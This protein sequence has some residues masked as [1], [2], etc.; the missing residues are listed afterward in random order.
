LKPRDLLR[1]IRSAALALLI[2][3]LTQTVG[4]LPYG[5]L[6]VLAR[7]L[8]WLLQRTNR[9][10]RERCRE[11]LALAF[12]E[13]GAEELERLVEGCFV[14]ASLNVMETLQLLARG[15][16]PLDRRLDIE[17]WE[18]VESEKGR[19]V[20][21]LSCHSGF[22]EL[23][24]IAGRRHGVQF[25][26]IGRQLDNPTFAALVRRI[27]DTAG[28]QNIERGSPEGRRFLRRALKG[29]APLVMLIDQDTK[30]DGT[31]VPF[32]GR[33]AFTP[34]GAAQMALGHDMRVVPAFFERRAGG[35]H[36]AR[37]LP[38]LDLPADP[39]GATAVM[40]GAI[41][42]HIRRHPEQW[43]WWHRRWRRQP[44]DDAG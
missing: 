40:T 11:H 33:P 44:A 37:F 35:R 38:A 15:P 21:L 27:R 10:H 28:G 20:L 39:T 41:E 34:L 32:F 12:P 36:V 7:G 4:R 43:V 6:A 3:V 17:G 42:A 30:V 13:L 8:A 31:W 18:N 25:F 2:P 5:A 9:R 14:N 24:G 23:L 1:A 22:W 29:E 19:R 26:G 16:A